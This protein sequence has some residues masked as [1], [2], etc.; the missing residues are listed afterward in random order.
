MNTER[1]KINKL[2]K[3]TKSEVRCP[4]LTIAMNAAI[5]PRSGG[6]GGLHIVGPST[7]GQAQCS[8]GW[9]GGFGWPYKVIVEIDVESG[10]PIAHSDPTHLE[11]GIL[12]TLYLRHAL[13]TPAA[14]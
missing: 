1:A 8:V 12:C 13:G 14:G 10:H 9:R 2:K 4:V 11:P 7:N 6:E 3:V 5:Q